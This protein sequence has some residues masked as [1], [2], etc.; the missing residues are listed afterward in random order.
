ML[1]RFIASI[2]GAG[3][4]QNVG[5][6]ADVEEGQAFRLI[7]AGIARPEIEPEPVETATAPQ[8]KLETATTKTKH[9]HKAAAAAK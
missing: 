5:E 7:A 8:P 9:T 2:A 4:V 3:W 1:I 6:V